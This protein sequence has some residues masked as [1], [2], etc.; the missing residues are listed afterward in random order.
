M[1]KAFDQYQEARKIAE[2][3]RNEKAEKY[4]DRIIHA[5]EDG[6]TGT[7]TFMA[8]RWSI[9]KLLND[10]DTPISKALETKVKRLYSKI[11]SALK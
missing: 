11:N 7:E 3:L 4:A 9:E 1:M 5:M 8:L 2:V 6:G 10:T